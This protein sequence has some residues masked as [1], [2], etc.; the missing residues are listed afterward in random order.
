[1]RHFYT[2]IKRGWQ[3]TFHIT[4][5]PCTL[6]EVEM[7]TAD[8][9]GPTSH[10]GPLL[11]GSPRRFSARGEA[12]GP[13]AGQPKKPHSAPQLLT[14][15]GKPEPSGWLLFWHMCQLLVQPPRPFS[16]MCSLCTEPG[17]G[18]LSEQS[19]MWHVKMMTPHTIHLSFIDTAVFCHVLFLDVSRA[20]IH[21]AEPG[22][23]GNTVSQWGELFERSQSK[24]PLNN[25]TY[26][27]SLQTT[28]GRY[29]MFN[30]QKNE[31]WK[32]REDRN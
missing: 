17:T 25:K 18:S 32:R 2:G 1:L 15:T 16:L 21:N 31:L 3:L 7:L 6:K 4:A 26:Y 27:L 5:K 30:S 14:D 24:L 28:C 13:R 23:S 29:D 12:S 9:E 20:R 22:H 8:L 11:P 19:S 10:S